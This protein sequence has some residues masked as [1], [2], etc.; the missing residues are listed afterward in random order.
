MPENGYHTTLHEKSNLRDPSHLPQQSTCA[1]DGIN[2]HTIINLNQETGEII[3]DNSR[4]ISPESFLCEINNL[5]PLI[6]MAY[7]KPLTTENRKAEIDDTEAEVD[8]KR[9]KPEGEVVLKQRLGYSTEALK[10]EIVMNIDLPGPTEKSRRVTATQLPS[11]GPH[12]NPNLGD[13]FIPTHSD[14]NSSTPSDTSS[15]FQTENTRLT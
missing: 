7:R 1:D 13:D 12:T 9:E 2:E 6:L 8:R 4:E 3:T 11:G 10:T 5:P 14:G 15:I